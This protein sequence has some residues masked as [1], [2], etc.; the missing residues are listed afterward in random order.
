MKQITLEKPSR[1]A[2]EAATR[3]VRDIFF[4]KLMLFIAVIPIAI[5]GLFELPHLFEPAD[6]KLHVAPILASLAIGSSYWAVALLCLAIFANYVP[7][8]G[9]VCAAPIHRGLWHATMF[10]VGLLVDALVFTPRIFL[11][12]VIDSLSQPQT[13]TANILFSR[14]TTLLLLGL[15]VPLAGATYLVWHPLYSDY[16]AH[17]RNDYETKYY[18]NLTIDERDRWEHFDAL[19]REA[20]NARTSDEALSHLTGLSRAV[21][22]LPYRDERDRSD[23]ANHL[24]SMADRILKSPA[25]ENHP[26]HWSKVLPDLHS[27]RRYIPKQPEIP[28]PVIDSVALAESLKYATPSQSNLVPSQSPSPPVA[29]TNT[30]TSTD[31]IPGPFQ[32]EVSPPQRRE[33]S[34]LDSTPTASMES[35]LP[36]ATTP[37]QKQPVPASRTASQPTQSIAK[38]AEPP[39]TPAATPD[40]LA[41]DVPP[42][43][44]EKGT[45][46]TGLSLQISDGGINPQVN[47]GAKIEIELSVKRHDADQFEGIVRCPWA[48]TAQGRRVRWGATA[49]ARGTYQDGEVTIKTTPLHVPAGTVLSPGT[50]TGTV[51]EGVFTGEFHGPNN[52]LSEVTLQ[53]RAVPRRRSQAK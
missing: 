33:P 53:L 22:Y 10:A 48:T 50:W 41:A 7:L 45:T 52:S 29:S 42:N 36:S 51:S 21:A 43:P 17:A 38:S 15:I 30:F 3:Y 24:D 12:S 35:L 25:D 27:L 11:G 1:E 20:L 23:A 5:V 31:E 37:P 47:D 13:T 16:I 9:P 32:S 39:N 2:N 49:S 18:L 4:A 46:W 44:F 28:G 8:F 19:V 40:E 26:A 6:S 14:Q 34:T